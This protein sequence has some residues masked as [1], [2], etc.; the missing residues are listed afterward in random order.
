MSEKQK[1]GGKTRQT[2]RSKK[3]EIEVGERVEG[4]QEGQRGFPTESVI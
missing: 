4:Q 1:E 3:A 2:K